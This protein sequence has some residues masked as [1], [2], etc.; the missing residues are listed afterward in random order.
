[1]MNHWAN[2]ARSRA[3]VLTVLVIVTASFGIWSLSD[4]PSAGQSPNLSVH[5]S[6][7][8]PAPF[9]LQGRSTPIS[10]ATNSEFT[11]QHSTPAMFDDARLNDVC[12][13][14][15][16]VGWA[17]GDR[18]VIWSTT[19]AGGSWNLQRSEFDCTLCS[20]AFLDHQ[21][22]WIAGGCYDP[23]TKTSSA[24]VLW[25][26]DGGKSWR[27]EESARLLPFARQ[28]KFFNR[29]EGWLRTD[30][31]AMFPS[32]LFHTKDGGRSWN[33]VMG[34][35][36]WRA[37]DFLDMTSGAL[38]GMHG[39]A[40]TIRR[41]NIRLATSLSLGLREAH[42]MQLE[43][44]GGGWLVGDGGLIMLTGTGGNDWQYPAGRVGDKLAELF[45]FRAVSVL[46]TQ[47]WIAGAP[48]S[49]VFHTPDAGHSWRVLPTGQTRPLHSVQFIDPQRGWAVGDLGVI[50]STVDGGQSWQTQ[51]SG[52]ARAAA[53]GVFSSNEQVPWEAFSALAAKDGF[54]TVAH[55][56]GRRDM[57]GG[58][59][60]FRE[61]FD[62]FHDAL[63]RVGG[64]S[65][66]VDWQF[67]LDQQG[68]AREAQH[69]LE[70]WD[71]ANDD[72]G[73]PALQERLVR[74]IRTWRPE[75]IIETDT[76]NP[77]DPASELI[78]QMVSQAVIVAA[79]VNRFPEHVQAGLPPWQVKKVIGVLPP[80]NRGQI[81][82]D[83]SSFAPRLEGSLSQHSQTAYAVT[84]PLEMAPNGPDN[85][86]FRIVADQTGSDAADRGIMG[87][88][89]LHP[90][91]DARRTMTEVADNA[92]ALQSAAQKFRNVKAILARSENSPELQSRLMGQVGDLTAGLDAPLAGRVLFNLAVSYHRKGQASLAAQIYEALVK[93][94]P[95]HPLAPA[96]ATWLIQYYASAEMS[97]RTQQ[98]E[99]TGRFSGA[100]TLGVDP[101]KPGDRVIDTAS[102]IE[103]HGT[104]V[105]VVDLRQ[106]NSRAAEA[107]TVGRM[108]EE[109][110]P[111][112]LA[113]PRL[114][115][116]LAAAYTNQGL[117]NNA[118]Q[119][120][121]RV[122]R[123]STD[124]AWRDCAAAETWLTHRDGPPPKPLVR[125]A[126]AMDKPY[127]DGSLDD[128]LWR[129]ATSVRLREESQPEGEFGSEALVATDGEF[130]YLAVRCVKSPT[131]DYE[132]SG[133]ARPRDA[134][135][136]DH[137]RVEFLIDIDRDYATYYRLTVDHRGWTSERCFDDQTWNPTWYV[138]SGGDESH[139]IA[140][141]AI[142]ITE[143]TPRLVPGS[144]VWALGVQR[145]IPGVGLES[146]TTPASTNIQPEGFGLLSF[147]E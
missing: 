9:G 108:L 144:T 111:Q 141:I 58:S 27:R 72:R 118:E 54:L 130:L 93:R 127:L 129:N 44:G 83:T 3:R 41:Q 64:T 24:V 146:W 109:L 140:E 17:V 25:T 28:I 52:G 65:S 15:P 139:W 53:L 30:S 11:G 126:T 125:C 60:K 33:P 114:Q 78:S 97:H 6:D 46:G 120:L 62:R 90:G 138:A 147:P 19:D 68:I 106:K 128:A 34:S 31:S 36:G 96:G 61:D 132:P 121:F 102:A 47:A 107:T 13:V 21:N 94:Y 57:A 79:D 23:Y 76:N 136:E 63:V 142:P 137:D 131:L 14:D 16:Q 116:P 56:I 91:G 35:G 124:V 143:L 134:N 117:V 113:K 86:G 18:G 22:G 50:L 39:A 95:Q 75:V 55:V 69:V 80:G 133:A 49:C 51:H 1:M 92:T 70:T 2:V 43:P 29:D 99:A 89:M 84:A 8:R 74:L 135:L 105:R 48:G 66:Q 71:T 45:D 145:V 98:R 115:F 119:L 4:D 26:R 85:W 77:T 81:N 88:I 5:T 87:G 37:A 122:L 59:E 42:R 32:G 12:F 100:S 67:P 123:R 103:N 20:A 38:A 101:T 73:L 110:S 7:S 112:L 10:L 40:A 82:I 104:E